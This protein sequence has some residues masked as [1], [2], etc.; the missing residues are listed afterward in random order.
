MLC[1]LGFASTDYFDGYFARKY[2]QTTDLG[3][4]LDPIA[5]KLFFLGCWLGLIA[6]KKVYVLWPAIFL[7][8][9]IFIM[10]LRSIALKRGMQLRVSPLA[11]V[12]TAAQMVL[13][14]WIVLNP[15]VH[16][17]D[18]SVLWWNALQE[19]L[20]IISL[21]LTLFTAYQY[22]YKLASKTR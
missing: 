16:M 1:A 5:D 13:I 2:H 15:Y 19:F 12:K 9:D 22:V 14:C 18:T 8:R 11:K 20:L 17:S 4:Q 3:A 10:G 6:T 7:G 21:S